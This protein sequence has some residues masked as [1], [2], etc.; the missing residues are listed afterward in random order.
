MRPAAPGM[1]SIRALRYAASAAWPRYKEAPTTTGGGSMSTV[2]HQ[3]RL[4]HLALPIMLVL[5]VV[6]L[7]QADSGPAHRARLPRP[8]VLGVS[9]LNSRA[10]CLAGTLGA[11]IRG[12]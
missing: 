12:K 4:G 3:S 8:I 6:P 11:L 2:I 1:D 9:G 5:T 10:G 7:A